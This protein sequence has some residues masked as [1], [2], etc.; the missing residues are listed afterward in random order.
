M[1]NN[2]KP[3]EV[4]KAIQDRD[5]LEEIC[6]HKT[7]SVGD[8]NKVSTKKIIQTLVDETQSVGLKKLLQSVTRDQLKILAKKIW[9]GK[10]IRFQ[11]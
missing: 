8:D 3:I 10:M 2:K 4:F 7:I 9:N 11:V 6:H 5:T 1:S